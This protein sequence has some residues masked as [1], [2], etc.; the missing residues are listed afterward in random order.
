MPSFLILD[1]LNFHFPM[2]YL[3]AFIY[4]LLLK[5]FNNYFINNKIFYEKMN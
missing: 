4:F 1:Y 2:D 3:R 5:Y